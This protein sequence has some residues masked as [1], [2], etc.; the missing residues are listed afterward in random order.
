MRIH[1]HVCYSAQRELMGQ[2]KGPLLEQDPKLQETLRLVVAHQQGRLD[3]DFIAKGAQQSCSSPSSSSSSSASSSC[4]RTA[5]VSSCFLRCLYLFEKLLRQVG[6]S[7]G[8]LE[9]SMS[10]DQRKDV[11]QD[12]EDGRV[13]VLLLSQY[14]GAEGIT[15]TSSSRMILTDVGLSPSM[16]EQVCHIK[17]ILFY[18][19]DG[20]LAAIR[21]IYV[22]SII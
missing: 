6:I 20:V 12:F 11:L 13:D 15:L 9:G 7:S 5:V 19:M 1:A 8:I 4:G 22:C 17:E 2:V 21:L 18:L 14:C 10:V 3:P 16:A